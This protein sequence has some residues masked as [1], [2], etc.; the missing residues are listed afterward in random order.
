MPPPPWCERCCDAAISSHGCD[1][2]TIVTGNASSSWRVRNHRSHWVLAT[3]GYAVASINYRYLQQADFPAQ[4]E[5]CKAAIRWLR[6]N[7][8]KY[9]FDADHIGV[10]GGSAGGHLVALLGTTGNVKDFDGYGGN[11]DQSSKVQC[12]IDLFGPLGIP[13]DG[14]GRNGEII[15]HIS[16]D[17]APFFIVHGDADKTVPINH[18]EQITAALKKAGVEVTFER[19]A[20]AGH[21]GKE[22]Q[23]PALH[24]QY[25]EFFDKHL[26]K[27]A[28]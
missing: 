25:L 2:R 15:P 3:K 7:A 6:A 17:S 20:G 18:S 5:D 22:F 8:K 28:K 12:V 11:T 23:T 9:N 14:G 1:G 19:I 21:G 27:A 16:K 10:M 24:K 26:K 13:K 4:I